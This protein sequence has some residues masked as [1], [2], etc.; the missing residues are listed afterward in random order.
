MKCHNCHRELD[1][2]T[3]KDLLN[4]CECYDDDDRM[5][6]EC[7]DCHTAH[8]GGLI[9]MTFTIDRIDKPGATMMLRGWRIIRSDGAV[10]GPFTT[11]REAE[12]LVDFFGT[13]NA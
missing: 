13:G 8:Q 5:V 7:D 12:I 3:N 6:F 11:R 9:E 10:L 4:R 2:T 1:K